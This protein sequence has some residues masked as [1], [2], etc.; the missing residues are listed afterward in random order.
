MD[1]ESAQINTWNLFGFH[2]LDLYWNLKT[3]ISNWFRENNIIPIID[4]I[5]YCEKCRKYV[6]KKGINV[7]CPDCNNLVH[8]NRFRNT[9]IL[10]TCI[11]CKK[12]QVSNR[13][14]CCFANQHARFQMKDMVIFEESRIVI[15]K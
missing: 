6:D 3:N 12:R 10:Y 7:I 2:S 15:E 8:K 13:F 4:W 5:P 14:S 1:I 9:Y 11:F